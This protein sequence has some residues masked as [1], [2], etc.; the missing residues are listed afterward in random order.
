MQ[1]QDS[2]STPFIADS[3]RSVDDYEYSLVFQNE[4]DRGITKAQRNA[5]STQYPMD[6]ST[7]PPS[8]EVFQQGLAQY[9]ARNLPM[10]DPSKDPYN[11][12][13]GRDMIPP[14]TQKELLSTYV[15][16]RPAD[17]TTYDA[18][19]VKELIDKIYSAKGMVADYRETQPN[20]YSIVSKRPKE[21][22]IYYDDEE[23]ASA[24]NKANRAAGED[25][26]IIPSFDK[27]EPKLKD[28]FFT[29]YPKLDD[30]ARDGKWDYTQWTPGLER[31][32]APT[33]PRDNWY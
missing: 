11:A 30:K 32:F 6:W 7:Q 25:V 28:P 14:L 3:I 13:S 4:G 16:K 20:V 2:G 18:E 29:Q 27:K 21:E 19:D 31:P 8:S 1:T 33:E 9:N 10:N 12:I 22:S 24:S 15:P 5:L 26:T 23:H 17:L